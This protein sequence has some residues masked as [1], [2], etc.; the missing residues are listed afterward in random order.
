MK[1]T[2]LLKLAPTDYQHHALLETMHVF[3]AACTSIAE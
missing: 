3:N 2:M 1:Q